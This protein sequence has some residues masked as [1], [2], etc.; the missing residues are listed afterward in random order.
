MIFTGPA[1]GSALEL[2]LVAHRCGFENHVEG[3]GGAEHRFAAYRF[4]DSVK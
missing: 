1:N 4:D 2:L 3:E